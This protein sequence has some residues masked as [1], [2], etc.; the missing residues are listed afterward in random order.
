LNY[1]AVYYIYKSIKELCMK[2]TT[3]PFFWIV[4]AMIILA[5]GACSP[6]DI[7]VELDHSEVPDIHA[8]RRHNSSRKRPGR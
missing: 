7:A 5:L 8:L 1:L 6:T 3:L 4:I 2:R